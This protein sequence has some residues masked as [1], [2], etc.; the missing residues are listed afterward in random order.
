MARA[1]SR[2]AAKAVCAEILSV[3]HGIALR[4]RAIGDRLWAI[5]VVA[6]ALDIVRPVG[7]GQWA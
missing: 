6:K 3:V 1:G 2:K 7:D 4:D 5:E